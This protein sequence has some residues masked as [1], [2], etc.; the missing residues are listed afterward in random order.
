MNRVPEQSGSSIVK[1]DTGS[2]KSLQADYVQVNW[3]QLRAAGNSPSDRA[4]LKP[5]HSLINK[6]A[7]LIG[8]S[9]IPQRSTS[10]HMRIWPKASIW[11][12][13][14]HWKKSLILKIV[15]MNVSSKEIPVS[16]Y[17]WNNSKERM[18]SPKRNICVWIYKLSV[19]IKY[20]NMVHFRQTGL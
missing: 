12:G 9:Q 5:W 10:S 11:E 8:D 16:W 2:S 20:F 15:K 1:F 6:S 13:N 3:K 17:Y 4:M 7:W 19:S 14:L 18:T